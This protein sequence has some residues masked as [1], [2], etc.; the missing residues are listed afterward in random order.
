MDALQKI[1]SLLRQIRDNN[2]SLLS[3]VNQLPKSEQQ[4]YSKKVAD[5]IDRQKSIIKPLRKQGL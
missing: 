1:D 3:Q 2:L 4:V 5:M